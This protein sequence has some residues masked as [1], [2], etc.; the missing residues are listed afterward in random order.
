MIKL[1][2]NINVY[3]HKRE[4]GWFSVAHH[5]EKQLL[6]SKYLVGKAATGDNCTKDVRGSA[7]TWLVI[8]KLLKND[9]VQGHCLLFYHWN[10]GRH[11]FSR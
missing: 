3:K 11:P 1:G 6:I 8:S 7:S 2:V 5:L 4:Q 9:Y 10:G